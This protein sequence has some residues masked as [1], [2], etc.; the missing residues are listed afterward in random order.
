MASTWRWWL[1][2]FD[3][4]FHVSSRVVVVVSFDPTDVPYPPKVSSL[5]F[6]DC[7]R[8][9]HVLYDIAASSPSGKTLASNA[10]GNYPHVPNAVWRI[11]Y[12]RHLRIGSETDDEMYESSSIVT[13][14][15]SETGNGKKRAWLA[16]DPDVASECRSVTSMTAD[17]QT[18]PN[19]H[20]ISLPSYCPASYF[21]CSK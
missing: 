1:A 6:L 18:L 4:L 19:A 7:H 20:S 10:A 15:P 13:S 16:S 2:F 17:R 9:R 8:G 3:L 21:D 14:V 12:L 11:W 5:T